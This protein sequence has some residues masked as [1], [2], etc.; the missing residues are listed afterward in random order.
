MQRPKMPEIAEGQTQNN[1]ILWMQRWQNFGEISKRL[2]IQKFVLNKK[3]FIL[4]KLSG[5][6]T[7]YKFLCQPTLQ[8]KTLKKQTLASSLQPYKNPN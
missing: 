8:E 7:K 1:D 4:F 6:F 2:M 3:L 5:L